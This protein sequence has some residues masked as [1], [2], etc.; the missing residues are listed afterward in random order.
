MGCKVTVGLAP[1]GDSPPRD[2][3]CCKAARSGARLIWA[4]T[5]HQK[6]RL[7]R[8]DAVGL[9]ALA[10][11]CPWATAIP[12]AVP[13]GIPL[14]IKGYDPVA[15]F[16]DGKPTRGVPEFEY[17]WDRLR[18]RFSRAEH[19]KLFKADPARYPPQFGTCCALC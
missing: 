10:V 19:R 9:V 16:A 18:Y 1:S 17:E 2:A 12:C 4:R 13:Q 6:T 14:A 3:A 15:Y 5:P 11:A 8:R 7:S